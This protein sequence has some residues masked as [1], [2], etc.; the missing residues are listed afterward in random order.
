M[1]TYLLAVKSLPVSLFTL[2]LLG[3]LSGCGPEELGQ[4]QQGLTHRRYV[5][6]HGALQAGWVWDDVAKRLRDDGETVTVV[7]L[8]AHGAD[9]LVP[10]QATLDAYVQAVAVAVHDGGSV[11]VHLVGHSLGGLVISQYAELNPTTVAD[12]I[13]VA[14]FVPASG[15]N[16]VSLFDPSSEVIQSVTADMENLT[17]NV[18]STIIGP[19]FCADCT[20]R[21]LEWFQEGLVPEPLVPLLA[22]VSLSPANFGSVT[23]KYLFTLEDRTITYPFQQAMASTTAIAKSATIRTSHQPQVSMPGLLKDAIKDLAK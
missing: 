19:G 8:P 2:L 7:N 16:A 23:K 14:G 20:A 9:S 13:Y 22:P 17:L 11:P 15:Q 21:K 12:L 6:V 1:K 4:G 18:P 10:A 3:T 5:L